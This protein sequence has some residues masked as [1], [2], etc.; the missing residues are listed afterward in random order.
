MPVHSTASLLPFN[1]NDSPVGHCVNICCGTFPAINIGH[2]GRY[3]LKAW[4]WSQPFPGK[5]FPKYPGC[6]K[7]STPVLPLPT[8]LSEIILTG[9]LQSNQCC[10]VLRPRGWRSHRRI[11]VAGY[12]G[13]SGVILTEIFIL[14]LFHWPVRPT[15]RNECLI[16]GPAE[17]T[18]VDPYEGKPYNQAELISSYKFSHAMQFHI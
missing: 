14:L 8:N 10:T 6:V 5:M 15:R 4:N 18:Q 1:E 3:T 2:T 9:L 11:R 16:S 17:Y 7:V 13:S 12:I